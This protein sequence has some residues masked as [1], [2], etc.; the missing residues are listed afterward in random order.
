[1]FS[2]KGMGQ[3]SNGLLM[4]PMTAVSVTNTP[5]T[6]VSMGYS[7]TGGTSRSS[8][9]HS[10]PQGECYCTCFSRQHGI[11]Q[12]S[13]IYATCLVSVYSSIVFYT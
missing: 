5:M 10:G 9:S 6:A 7:N 11:I 13:C 12:D 1:M 4:T 2:D 3:V 8:V